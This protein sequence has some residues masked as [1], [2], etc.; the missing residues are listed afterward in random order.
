MLMSN[1]PVW[2]NYGLQLEE[3]ERAVRLSYAN[4]STDDAKDRHNDFIIAI[5]DQISNIQSSLQESAPSGGKVSPS[6]VRLDEGECNELALFLSA[7]SASGAVSTHVRDNENHKGPHKASMPEHSK[8]SSE[9][10]SID[11]KEEKL[12]GHRRAASASADIGAWN[13]AIMDDGYQQSSSNGQMA[14][15]PRKIP[16]LSGFL[17]AMDSV[18]KLK[19]SRNGFRKLKPMDSDQDADSALPTTFQS[20][21]VSLKLFSP[22]DIWI[23]VFC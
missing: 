1:V 9:W 20:D 14:K 22:S 19:W 15:P 3:F 6:W 2:C 7:P 16:S 10:A 17:N 4:R 5:Q 8:N 18:S 21:R 11:S 12:Y 23:F 13:V